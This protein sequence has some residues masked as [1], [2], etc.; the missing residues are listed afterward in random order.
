M[1]LAVLST[2]AYDPLAPIEIDILSSSE[3]GETSRRVNRVATLDGGAVFN[4]FGQTDA[5]RTITLRWA[6]VSTTHESAIKRLVRLYTKI[7]VA[8]EDGVFLAAPESY[9]P[10]EGESRLRLLVDRRLDA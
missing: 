2:E 1:P 6:P 10:G 7:V 9:T 4:D 3:L 5:D 8:T